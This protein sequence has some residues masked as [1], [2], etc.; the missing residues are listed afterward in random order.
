MIELIRSANHQPWEKQEEEGECVYVCAW[1][2]VLFSHVPTHAYPHTQ[3]Q[4][5]CIPIPSSAAPP[6]KHMPAAARES[7]ESLSTCSPFS[8][9][10]MRSVRKR[11]GTRT[12]LDGQRCTF[13]FRR[14]CFYALAFFFPSFAPPLI[15]RS[16]PSTAEKSSFLVIMALVP[17]SCFA[18]STGVVAGPEET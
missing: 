5:L 15:S 7:T 17:K 8:Y 11:R 1:P 2:S 3:K 14:H 18:F 12:L 10:A 4:Q 16:R 6:T 13:C 9:K